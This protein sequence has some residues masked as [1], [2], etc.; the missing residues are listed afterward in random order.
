MSLRGRLLAF[1]AFAVPAGSIIEPKVFLVV[2]APLLALALIW[3]GRREGRALPLFPWGA[4]WLAAAILLW[5][6]LSAAWS[7]DPPNTW[8]KLGDLCLV[9][10]GALL[11]FGASRQL[12]PRDGR[13]LGAALAL[14]I[15]IALLAQWSELATGG[16]LV[17]TFHE[18]RHE[19]LSYLVRGISVATILA[20]AA[21][22]FLHR[23]GHPRL[24]IALGLF[25][26]VTLW[27]TEGTAAALSASVGAAAALAFFAFPRRMVTALAV[28]AA[29]WVLAVPFV[30]KGTMAE[31]DPQHLAARPGLISAYH[32]LSI[33]G[34]TAGKILERPVLGY[35]LR[36]GRKVPGGAKTFTLAGD[37]EHR[38][39]PVF[40]MHPH[41][42]PLEWW[43]ELGLPGAV[44]GALTI[45]LLF[46]WPRRIRDQATRALVIGQLV[47]AFGILNLS[48]G[49]WQIWWLVTLVL[50]AYLTLC[51]LES[52]DRADLPRLAGPSHGAPR[53]EQQSGGAP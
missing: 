17:R 44:L 3:L 46:G 16:F 1:A 51:V 10:A 48:F 50:A 13:V 18:G 7:L 24:A 49:V 32:R 29:A 19:S 43:L 8:K 28:I 4:A 52:A 9:A 34:F 25:A 26:L 2:L 37:P 33:W 5:A 15:L 12:T 42:G 36:A 31:L 27:I 30:M 14:G 41:N 22:I 53:P 47:T 20:W 6:G 23:S 11:L 45:Y 21:V 38:A 39:L 35:G 40:S